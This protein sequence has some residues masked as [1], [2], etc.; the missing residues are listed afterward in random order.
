MLNPKVDMQKFIDFGF[1]P[2][3]GIPKSQNCLYLCVA[4]GNQMIFVSP[5]VYLINDWSDKDS[6]IHKKANCRYRDWR[7]ALDITYDLIKAGY[8]TQHYG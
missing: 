5:S 1:K 6:R 4:R 2:C 8:L 7:T 3:K